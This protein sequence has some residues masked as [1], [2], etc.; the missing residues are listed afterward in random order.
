MLFSKPY[1]LK[2]FTVSTNW[3]CLLLSANIR[4]AND[5]HSLL[6]SPSVSDEEKSFII[7]ILPSVTFKAFPCNI[8]INLCLEM[9]S[10]KVLWDLIKNILENKENGLWTDFFFK[11]FKNNLCENYQFSF[12][13][14]T[15][16]S[17]CLLVTN[18]LAYC[19][20][21]CVG[22]I[23]QCVCST[24]VYITSINMFSLLLHSIEYLHDDLLISSSRLG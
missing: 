12:K 3:V 24:N 10:K 7:L 16:N 6:S 4:V 15:H 13:T 21:V 1:L 8:S 5:E 23:N 20:N 9:H 22:I 2:H 19:T 18:T 17:L 11:V 14:W